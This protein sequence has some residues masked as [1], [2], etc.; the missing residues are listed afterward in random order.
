[1][2]K[3]FILTLKKT[4]KPMK[5]LGYALIVSDFDGTLLKSDGT[6]GKETQ[7]SIRRFMKNGGHFAVSTGRT[8]AGILPRVRELGLRGVVACGQGASIVDIERGELILDGRMDN[9]LAVAVCKKMEEM[10]LHI[11]VYEPWGFYSN[12]DDEGLKAYEDVVKVKGKVIADKPISQF[13][14]ESGFCPSKLS[15]LVAAEDRDWVYAELSKAFQSDTCY[16]TASSEYLVEVGN[17]AY[18]KGSSVAFLAKYYGV[19]PEKVICIG[20]QP[21]DLSMLKAAGLGFAVKN[22]DKELK[23][24]AIVFAYTND[25]DAVGKIIEEYA[26]CKD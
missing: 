10:Q 25:E 18:T 17:S 24:N 20:D 8:P 4:Y 7:N 1:M 9:S 12:M 11:H 6:V 14:E 23:D 22:A 13:L 26:Y 16:V 21:N 19:Q 15:V 2:Q 5:K 3:K